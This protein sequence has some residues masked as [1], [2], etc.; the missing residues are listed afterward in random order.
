MSQ[1]FDRLAICPAPVKPDA[2]LKDW[3]V[4]NPWQIAAKGKS[5]SGYDNLKKKYVGT[6]IENMGTSITFV[7]GTYAAGTKTF[8]FSGQYDDPVTGGK[9][10][11]RFTENVAEKDRIVFEW[12]ETREGKETK[13]MEIVYTRKK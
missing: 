7:E 5:L 3:W 10:A 13:S 8:T 6:W 1:P 12:Y 9:I 11:F 2:R 4:E